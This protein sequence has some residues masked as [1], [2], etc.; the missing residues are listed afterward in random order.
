MERLAPQRATPKPHRIFGAVVRLTPSVEGFPRPSW[1]NGSLG[2]L[3][4]IIYGGRAVATDNRRTRITTAFVSSFDILGCRPARHGI[5]AF[6]SFVLRSSA[7]DTS[8]LGSFS[9]T[10]LAS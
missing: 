4:H 1:D 9:T 2:L 8:G 10:R 7:I 3:K 6:V 5:E